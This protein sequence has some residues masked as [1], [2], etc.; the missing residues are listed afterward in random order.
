MN[1]GRPPIAEHLRRSTVLRVRV[2]ERERH[3]LERAAEHQRVN[4]SEWIRQ[5]LRRLLPGFGG[6]TR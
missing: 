4:V 5:A 3:A 1:I 6:G 2:T